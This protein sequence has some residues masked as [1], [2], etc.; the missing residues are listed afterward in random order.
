LADAV[1]PFNMGIRM[2]IIMIIMI[3]GI[4]AENILVQSVPVVWV[5]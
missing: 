5:G 3:I 4:I 2:A 1:T